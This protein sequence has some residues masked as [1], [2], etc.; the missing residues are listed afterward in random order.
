MVCDIKRLLALLGKGTINHSFGGKKKK[1][2]SKKKPVLTI[3]IAKP[4]RRKSHKT[5]LHNKS[6]LS[7]KTTTGTAHRAPIKVKKHHYRVEEHNPTQ[8]DIENAIIKLEK[9]QIGKLV[10]IINMTPKKAKRSHPTPPPKPLKSEFSYKPEY[11][12]KVR[13]EIHEKKEEMPR[14]ADYPSV[15]AHAEAIRNW[16]Q[17]MPHLEPIPEGEGSGTRYI[18]CLTLERELINYIKPPRQ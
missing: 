7:N 8:R 10:P 11:H 9:T 3:S 1:P 18:S 17:G 16:T 15:H 6:R 12:F 5:V 2:V 4:R 13:K 14:L